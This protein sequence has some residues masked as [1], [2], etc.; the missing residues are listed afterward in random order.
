M[1]DSLARRFNLNIQDS[2][3]T[4]LAL[5]PTLA[6]GVAEEMDVEG[7]TGVLG[8]R[9]RRERE[10]RAREE[11]ERRK[12]EEE[13]KRVAAE[14][15]RASSE[16]EEA[17][18]KKEAQPNGD[19][20]QP[21]GPIGQPLHSPLLPMPNNHAL[22]SASLNP[23]AP[24]FQPRS[25]SPPQA[26][27]PADVDSLPP[28]E[29]EG[30]EMGTSWAEVVKRDGTEHAEGAEEKRGGEGEREVVVN[31]HATE[32]EENRGDKGY[33]V[34]GAAADAE[35]ETSEKEKPVQLNGLQEED[36]QEMVE[37]SKPA[38]PEKTKAELWNSIKLLC[39]SLLPSP[40]K[41]LAHAYARTAFTRLFTSIYLLV[42]LSLQTHV[43]LAL[44]GRS[45]YVESLLSA[46]PPRSPSP[47]SARSLDPLPSSLP[48][49]LDD[50]ATQDDDLESALYAAKSLPPTPA[51]ERKDVERK[52]LTFSWWLLHEG[53]KVVYRRVEQAVEEVVGP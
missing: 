3:F 11:E 29:Q 42:L 1:G 4:V 6:A 44:L 8:E 45:A 34:D 28:R 39:P 15:E 19:A 2:Q 46:L 13:E 30:G 41:P 22:A 40:S 51:E 9:A 47:S 37:A 26:A 10:E 31:G 20:A 23:S 49:A 25:P 27:E 21:P 16:A 24:V 53:W 43:Q 36:R 35:G 17:A 14:E 12:R 52:Y 48:P 33:E 18:N 38:Q 32:G 50:S 7:L 5:L